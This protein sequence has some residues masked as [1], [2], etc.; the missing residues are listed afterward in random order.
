MILIQELQ[1]KNPWW[2]KSD[3]LISE[4]DWPKRDIYS[5]LEKNLTHPLMLNILGLRRVGKSTIIKQLIA[6]LLSSGIKSKNIFYYLFD[7]S[8]QIKTTEFLDNVL[9]LYLTDVQ[10]KT[11]SNLD[12]TLYVFL[13]EIQYIEN[14]Q[15]IVKKYYD[16][17]NKKIKFILTGSQS[18]LLKGKSKES[19]AGRV[20][21]YYLPPLSFTEF[22]R[23]NKIEF[24]PLMDF[25]L[26]NLPKIFFDLSSYSLTNGKKV[27]EISKEYIING[28]FPESRQLGSDENKLEYILESVLGKI[29][30]DC[31]KIYKIEKSEEF[32]LVVY[33][34]L[35][36]ISSTFELK[37]IAREIGISSITIEKYFEYLKES[38]IFEILF[39]YHKS[40]IKQGRI[41][42]KV[43]TTCINFNCAYNHY[44][45]IHIDEVPDVFGKIIENLIFNILKQKYLYPN[46]S[47]WR[48][49]E[50]E[51]DFIVLNDKKILP[52]EVKITKNIDNKD[53][54]TICE[55]IYEKKID[56]GI[57]ITK[58][59][60]A[61]KQVYN[62]TLYFIP[63][64]LA[65]LL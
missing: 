43:Y 61:K 45:E 44:K 58:N 18:I 54:K 48:K 52:I 29:M 7:Y 20:F 64:Y 4:K 35:N 37:N 9:A 36:N 27:Y 25:D 22:L 53:F 5:I 23:I 19:L 28:Q 11:V 50:K 38:Y 57:V 63:Y 26:F 33:Q 55:Y 2:L 3:Y 41:L 17:S 12:E 42:K 46:I 60:L 30:E 51:I 65:L 62:Q 1:F 13:D 32:K 49:G 16:I 40:L 59:E 24:T 34:L 47:F 39:K 56:Y 15:T 21:D 31:I 8:S 10:Q 14:W 6:G